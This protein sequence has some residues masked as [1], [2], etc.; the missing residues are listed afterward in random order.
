MSTVGSN[1]SAAAPT[2]SPTLQAGPNFN[3][4]NGTPDNPITLGDSSDDDIR[5]ATISNVINNE[6]LYFYLVACIWMYMSFIR[7]NFLT[8][9]L[10]QECL[11]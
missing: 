7:V 4:P 3:D 8:S 11:R 2:Q 6:I 5:S 9:S 1:G 10:R